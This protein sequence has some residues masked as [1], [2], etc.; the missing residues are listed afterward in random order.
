MTNNAIRTKAR[1]LL[2]GNYGRLAIYIIIFFLLKLLASLLPST[3]FSDVSHPLLL[4]GQLILS[5]IFTAFVNMLNVGITC[6]SLRIC[7]EKPFSL[8]DLFYAF[9][10]NQDTFLTLELLFTIIPTILSIPSVFFSMIVANYDLSLVAYFGL[11]IGWSLLTTFIT[12]IILLRLKF[13]IYIVL[14]TPS[15]KA[16]TALK[17]AIQLTKGHTWQLVRL[18]CSFIGLYLLSIASI[19]TGFLFV[20]PYIETSFCA[21][22]ESLIGNN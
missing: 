21:F 18:M 5:F 6:V 20:K 12:T 19:L 13:A 14:D 4:V 1:Y 11:S 22:Y 16:R 3:I 8:A 7:R 9:R 2:N 15:T 10:F 17:N